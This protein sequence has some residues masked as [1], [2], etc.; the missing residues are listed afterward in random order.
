MVGGSMSTLVH[1]KPMSLFPCLGALLC[2]PRLE[3]ST[4]QSWG[5]PETDEAKVG[6]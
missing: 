5:L 4:E 2:S 1:R 6:P 3:T